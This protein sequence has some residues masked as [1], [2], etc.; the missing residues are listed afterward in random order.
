MSPLLNKR[1]IAFNRS[2]ANRPR[3]LPASAVDPVLSRAL[4]RIRMQSL[5]RLPTLPLLTLPAASAPAVGKPGQLAG[6]ELSLLC[7]QWAC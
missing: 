6:L 3:P 1:T 5:F 4:H 2:A 7:C